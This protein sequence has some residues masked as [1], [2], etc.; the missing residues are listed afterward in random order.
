MCIALPH[1]VHLPAIRSS[2]KS[3]SLE[4]CMLASTPQFEHF[5]IRLRSMGSLLIHKN[6]ELLSLLVVSGWYTVDQLCARHQNLQKNNQTKLPA[7]RRIF[8]L[9]LPDNLADG[10]FV[11]N[12][13][14]HFLITIVSGELF[15]HLEI[16]S[17]ANSIC[18]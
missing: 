5:I 7:P 11:S 10:S 1:R 17:N 18:R 6:R 4:S 8:V 3:R 12:N 14:V 13:A 9:K 2:F 16:K 15:N